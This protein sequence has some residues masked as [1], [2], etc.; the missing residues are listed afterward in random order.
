MNTILPINRWAGW[1]GLGR[2]S[3][4]YN[5]DQGRFPFFRL[6]LAER[7][8]SFHFLPE[9]A[10]PRAGST[11][12]NMIILTIGDACEREDESLRGKQEWKRRMGEGEGEG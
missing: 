8:F 11:V 9:A 5:P 6:W 3:W 12:E 1:E 4:N 10:C 2:Q 7:L